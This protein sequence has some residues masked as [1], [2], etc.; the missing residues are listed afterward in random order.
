MKGLLINVTAVSKHANLFKSSTHSTLSKFV[1]TWKIKIENLFYIIT[2]ANVVLSADKNDLLAISPRCLDCFCAPLDWQIPLS[3]VTNKSPLSDFAWAETE[4]DGSYALQ[5]Q[6]QDII[7]PIQVDLLYRQPY[8]LTG[9]WNGKDTTF[10]MRTATLYQSPANTDNKLSYKPNY[11]L[12][13]ANRGL[14][15]AD[16]DAD[17]FIGV[18]SGAIALD[19]ESQCVGLYVGQGPLMPFKAS[20]NP[21]VIS[22]SISLE[23]TYPSESSSISSAESK[24]IME[25]LDRIIDNLDRMNAILGHLC[26]NNLTRQDVCEQLGMNTNSRPAMFIPS[27]ILAQISNLVSVSVA[28]LVGLPA[29]YHNT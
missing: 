5:L 3:Y 2:P 27:T 20:T 14:L 6:S 13:A 23:L 22:E 16:I 25:S 18:T 28:D 9:V 12:K 21:E 17:G 11:T 4:D 10:D 29:T 7:S 1:N 26:D 24:Q 8:A 19:T 15:Y